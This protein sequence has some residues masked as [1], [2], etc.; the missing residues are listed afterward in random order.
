MIWKFSFFSGQ[1]IERLCLYII[2]GAVGEVGLARQE[3]RPVV[4]EVGDRGAVGRVEAVP[5]F[6]GV[7]E[8]PML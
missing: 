5:G 2:E 6:T 3:D 7:R 8:L 1:S 4:V